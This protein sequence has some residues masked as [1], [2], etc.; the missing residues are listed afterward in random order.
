MRREV[1]EGAA[2]S[3]AP[4]VPENTQSGG[5][6]G[7]PETARAVVARHEARAQ[8]A[9][10]FRCHR[11][12]SGQVCH[13]PECLRCISNMPPDAITR[14]RQPGFKGMS[15]PEGHLASNPP[16]QRQFPCKQCGGNL[17]F[18]PGVQSL[19]CPYCGTV[20]EIPAEAGARV[21]EEDYQRAFAEC[22][23][24]ED[25]HERITVKCT[26][27]GAE[28]TLAPNVTADRCPFCGAAIV[29]QGATKKLIRP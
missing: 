7:P 1:H 13:S 14:T 11:S 26:T 16:S 25:L 3:R 5:T 2:E 27:C 19:K 12:L 21:E 28:T 6:S 4:F 9:Q 10:L 18:E 15:K 8:A 20:N 24:E 29:A 23:R 22:C 17:V